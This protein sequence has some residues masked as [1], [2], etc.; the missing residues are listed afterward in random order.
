MMPKDLSGRL[1]CVVKSPSGEAVDPLCKLVSMRVA[2]ET[3]AL[4]AVMAMVLLSFFTE[5]DWSR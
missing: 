3:S 4:V 5:N 2:I 1:C